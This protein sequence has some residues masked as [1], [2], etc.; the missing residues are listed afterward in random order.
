VY[1]LL[2]G[3][4]FEEGLEGVDFWLFVA[5]VDEKTDDEEDGGRDESSLVVA[6]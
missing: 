5:D 6:H 1:L 2:A 3:L 4:V